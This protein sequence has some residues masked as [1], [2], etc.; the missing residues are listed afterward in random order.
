MIEHRQFATKVTV[1]FVKREDGGLRAYCDEV[2][3]FFLSGADPRAVM[4]DV[5]PAIELLLKV[6]LEIPVNVLPLGYGVYHLK[7]SSPP[8][9]EQVV[10]RPEYSVEYVVQKVA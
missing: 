7:E 4:R 8:S 1:R 2:D 3:G 10:D 5:I 9:I 6:N